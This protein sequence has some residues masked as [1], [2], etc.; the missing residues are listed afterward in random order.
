M[1]SPQRASYPD[2]LAERACGVVPSISTD[3]LEK[4]RDH[5]SKEI[6]V[7]AAKDRGEWVAS[8]SESDHGILVD[9]ESQ[10]VKIGDHN[11]LISMTADSL[12]NQMNRCRTYYAEG[13]VD[14]ISLPGGVKMKYLPGTP[15]R[16]LG[17]IKLCVPVAPDQAPAKLCFN[18]TQLEEAAVSRVNLR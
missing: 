10:V 11:L 14:G 15:G 3:K 12:V 18:F 4:L 17:R 1:P 13:N 9:G 5:A 7:R 6:A 16:C 2:I 8:L